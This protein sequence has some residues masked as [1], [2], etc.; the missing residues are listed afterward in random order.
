M[1]RYRLSATQPEPLFA[2]LTWYER[3]LLGV[4]ALWVLVATPYTLFTLWSI[5]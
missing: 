3:A 5:R 2:S 4:T 1:S